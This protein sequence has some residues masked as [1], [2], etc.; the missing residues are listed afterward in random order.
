VF[1]RMQLSFRYLMANPVPRRLAVLARQSSTMDSLP[2][3]HTTDTDPADVNSC[4]R[5]P[6]SSVQR[7]FCLA[8]DVFRDAT[9]NVPAFFEVQDESVPAAFDAIFA[10]HL[11]FRTSSLTL[12]KDT[13][14]LWGES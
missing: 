6:P 12:A 7:R 13:S 1:P 8:Q 2:G 11:I 9:Y 4:L 14:K 5:H 10:E 3:P